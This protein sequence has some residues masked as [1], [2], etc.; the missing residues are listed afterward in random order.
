MYIRVSLKYWH[1]RFIMDN[2]S[3]HFRILIVDDSQ[4]IHTV[5]NK[6]LEY[7]A[8]V[9]APTSRPISLPTFKIDSAYQGEAAIPMVTKALADKEPYA[10]AFVD[11]QMPPGWDGVKTIQRIWEIDKDIQVVICTAGSDYSWEET[12]AQLGA[13]NNFLIL[14]KPFDTVTMRQLACALTSKWQLML[15]ARVYMEDLENQVA[16]RTKQLFFQANHDALTGLP[17]RTAMIA[18]VDN[19][20][21]NAKPNVMIALCLLDLDRFKL[22]NDSLT[23]LIGDQLLQAVARRLQESVR[24]NEFIISRLG[25]DE[26]VVAAKVKNEEEASEL[27]QNLLDTVSL[28]FRIGYHELAITSSAGISLYPRDGKDAENLCR[29]ADTAMYSAKE[30]G[31]NN[32]QFYNIGLNQFGLERLEL[33]NQLFRGIKKQEFILHY[34]PEINLQDGH[35]DAFEALI[36]WQHPDRGLIMPLE[37]VPV[38]EDTGQILQIGEWVLIKACKQNKIWQNNGLPKVRIGVNVAGRQFEQGDEL[39]RIVRET[40]AE[41]Q[42]AP[43]YLEIELSENIIIKSSEIIQTVR[44]LKDLGVK[45]ALDDFGTG[46]SN[47]SYLKK[48]PVDRIKIDRIYTQNIGINSDDEAIIRAIIAVADSLNVT[49][50]AEGVENEAQLEFLREEGCHAVQG[51]YFSK[52]LPGTEVEKFMNDHNKSADKK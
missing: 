24:S 25:G 48:L 36:R 7:P 19:L 51:Y 33:E 20:I 27:A 9:T 37:F 34:Q 44:S 14:K 31:P 42:L 30:R 22:I 11:I 18:D 16:Q 52:P 4:D 8:H 3:G 17:N 38:A 46:H 2:K 43:E 26:F 10:L 5:F 32:F 1:G 21:N 39:I 13:I 49:V 12:V 45:I 41:S 35:V 29:N 50:I 23:H 28:P 40:L 47:L 6:I 15:D